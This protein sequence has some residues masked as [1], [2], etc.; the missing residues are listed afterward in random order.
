MRGEY[1]LFCATCTFKNRITPACA[2]STP[3]GGGA[4]PSY[5]DHP[6]LRGEYI[7]RRVWKMRKKGSPPLA[8]GVL[9]KPEDMK[10]VTRITPA[11]AGSTS[12]PIRECRSSR[13]HPRLRGEYKFLAVIAHGI[14][15]S[16]PLARGVRTLKSL[17]YSELRITPACAGSTYQ[18]FVHLLLSWDHPRLRG[19]YLSV[20]HVAAA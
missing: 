10:S 17:S 18:G 11:C 9:T 8:R 5:R 13:D 20:F 15:G 14:I 16:P 4:T 19:E 2:G 3:T 6:R 1:F 7:L 12:A